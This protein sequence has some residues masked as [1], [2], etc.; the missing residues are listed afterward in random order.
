MNFLRLP[1][2]L[3]V[4]T[5]EDEMYTTYHEVYM[6]YILYNPDHPYTI[7]TIETQPEIEIQSADE[8]KHLILNL[9]LR[10]YSY[11]TNIMDIM[12]CLLVLTKSI[13]HHTMDVCGH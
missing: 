10:L 2:I 3:H 13:I 9:S 4:Y 6:E 11:T 8:Y 7:N 5:Y 1:A 12:I